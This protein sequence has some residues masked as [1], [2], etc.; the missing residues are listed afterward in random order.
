MP[1]RKNQKWVKIEKKLQDN[2]YI[3]E[4]KCLQT[5]LKQDENFKFH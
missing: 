2:S 3:T 5:K 1:K 4:E